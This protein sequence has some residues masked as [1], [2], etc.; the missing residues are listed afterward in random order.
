MATG[1]QR[2][3]PDRARQAAPSP[4]VEFTA[5]AHEHTEPAFDQ[6]VTLSANRQQLGP[7]DI[8]AYGFMR[9]LVILCELSGGVGGTLAADGP[10]S[11]IAEATLLDVNGAPI[12]GPLS[13][14]NLFVANLFGAYSWKQDPRLDPD[15]STSVTAF[16]FALRLPVEIHHNNGLGAL[17]NQN[18]AA[19]YKVRV[20]VGSLTD[21]YSVA[22]TTP[23]ALRVRGI[24][25]AWSQPNPA[26]LA[27]RPQALVPPRHGTTQYWSAVPGR[28]VVAGAQ[29][30]PI[31]RVGNLIRNL[32]FV[33]R[34]AAGVRDNTVFPTDPEI[35]W[36][37][38]QLISEP[39]TFRRKIMAE[40]N[41]LQDVPTGVFAY[42]FTHDWQNKAGDGTPE[43]WL[44][45]VQSSRLELVGNF[46][47]G[48]SVDILTNDVAPVEVTPAERFM[49]RSET[50]FAP[51]AVGVAVVG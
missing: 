23:G 29:T 9:H 27:G 25:E 14:F 43:L 47:L 37:A 17:A 32:I 3:R 34:T 33:A 46:S 36:D 38:R 39:R 5:A 35:R 15:Y 19:A 24:L 7:F 22:P 13:G 6:T 2:K 26:D 42:Q 44:P 21:I 11:A 8:P 48:G 18:S 1:T 30:I 45:T 20:T 49:E 12:V 50:G 41:S 4:L 10:F 16:A 40:R 28:A 31:A 51:D